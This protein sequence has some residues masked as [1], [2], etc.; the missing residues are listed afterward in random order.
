MA[1]SYGNFSTES[2]AIAFVESMGFTPS[3]VSP[4]LWRKPEMT[5]GNLMEAP[6]ETIA[7]VRIVRRFVR[8]EY[9]S[10]YFQYEFL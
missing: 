4:G 8:P 6:R 10:D 1:N 3:K 2:E 5:G 7:L 9:G